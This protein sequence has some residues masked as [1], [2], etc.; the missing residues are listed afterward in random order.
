MARPMREWNSGEINNLNWAPN[1][2][3]AKKLWP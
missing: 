3:M 1:I 2:F